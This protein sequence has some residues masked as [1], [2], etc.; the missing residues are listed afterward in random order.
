MAF[1]PST[2]TL[3]TG[4]FD[5]STAQPDPNESRKKISNFEYIANEAKKGTMDLAVLGQSI[6]D[7][8]VLDPFKGTPGGIGERFGANIKRLEKVASGIT[9]AQQ[10]MKAPSEVS[11]FLG[12]GARM[13]SDPF[14]LIGV[15]LK[16]VGGTVRGVAERVP[17]MFGIGVVS[18]AGGRAGEEIEK[19][20]TSQ[21]SGVG[22]AIGALGAGIKG[23]AVVAPVVKAPLDIVEQVY[24]K[25][26]T[27]KSDPDA[28]S[29]AIA[30]TSAKRLL[31]AIAKEQ[32]V[33]NLDSVVDDF[34]RIS[35]SLNKQDLPL[36]FAMS[37]NAIVRAEVQRLAKTNPAMRQR[38]EEEFAKLAQNIDN[39]ANLIFGERYAPVVGAETVSVKNAVK[40]RQEIDNQIETLSNRLVPNVSDVS[41]GNAI[42]NLVDARVSAARAEMA[43]VYDDILKS[44][45][46]ANAKLPANAV[47]GI[48]TFIKDNKLRDVFG[49]GTDA[50]RQIMSVWGPKE[51]TTQPSRII[52]PGQEPAQAVTSMSFKDVPFEQVESLK[53][54]INELQRGRLTPDEARKLNQLEEV[55]NEA[56]KSIPGNFDA[57][58]RAADLA[59][60]EKVGVPF[61]AQGIKDIDS[62]KYAEQVAPVIIKNVSSLRQ[63]LGAVGDEGKPIA[64]NAILSDAYNKIVK[65]GIL[66]PNLL[67]S[68]LARNE[69]VLNQLPEVKKEL[70]ES[71]INVGFL[72]K[73]SKQLDDT[74][75]AAQKTIADNFVT[76][77]KDSSGVSLPDYKSIVDRVIRDPGFEQSVFR[78]IKDL[79]AN[80]AKA[81]RNSM[82]AE[83]LNIARN[84]PDGGIA[85]LTDARNKRAIENVFGVGYQGAVRDLLKISDAMNRSDVN[86]LS[87][88]IAQ[89]DLDAIGKYGA[90]VGF[91][92]LDI[93]YVTSTLR[94]RIASPVQKVVRLLSRVQVAR[95][96]EDTDEAIFKLLMDVDGLKALQKVSKE[97][98]FNI[99][100]PIGLKKISSSIANAIPFYAYG[101]VKATAVPP[102]ESVK[103][104][105]AVMGGFE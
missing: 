78:Q 11:K 38:I 12:A 99:S 94:D 87:S 18:E 64:R 77:I 19:A 13:T 6:I 56:R 73:A 34:N 60:Y 47:E 49:R 84:N 33:D 53:R 50:D 91:P 83:L 7:T 81:V 65:D 46:E 103:Q 86:R 98:D 42:S 1:D 10:D 48:Y 4:G 43:P 85:F 82:K 62:K 89:S 70:Q 80:S 9:G 66:Q 41:I 61:G 67:K 100:N 35:Q 24:S 97:L 104:Q 37:D 5:H 75:A 22:R 27:V 102:Q 26:K 8:F 101:A 39:R 93:P 21:D 3:E 92:G 71:L 58:L 36:M 105:E 55:V 59:Y 96:R 79:D 45:K 15:P 74:A 51:V 76:K 54:R 29:Q 31:E 72:A 95:T 23:A 63:F 88:V 44:A 25:Y 16:T 2:A 32:G 57:R 17:S 90:S 52:I 68:Y 28:A 40:R 14:G 69:Q 20:I 30:N